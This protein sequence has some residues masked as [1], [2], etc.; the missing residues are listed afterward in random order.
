[1]I[2]PLDSRPEE[3]AALGRLVGHWGSVEFE[4][5]CLLGTL[6]GID[7]QKAELVYQSFVS[8]DSKII[9]LRRLNS[10]FTLNEAIKEKAEKLLSAAKELNTERNKYIHSLWGFDESGTLIKFVGFLTNNYKTEHPPAELTASDI[11]IVVDKMHKLSSELCQ[12]QTEL[13]LSKQAQ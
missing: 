12:V 7:T 5:Q 11:Q 6:L 4:L 2:I 1:M 13:Q 8:A 3:A 9:L 10:Q